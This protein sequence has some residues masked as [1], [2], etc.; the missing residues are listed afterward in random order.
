MHICTCTLSSI[1]V[2]AQQEAWEGH[3]NGHRVPLQPVA[4]GC[5]F[6]C[7][8][9]ESQ[10]TSMTC[11]QSGNCAQLK[12]TWWNHVCNFWLSKIREFWT[13]EDG[14]VRPVAWH[15]V[16]PMWEGM[17]VNLIFSLISLPFPYPPPQTKEAET[18]TKAKPSLHPIQPISWDSNILCL[19]PP[20]PSDTIHSCLE[21][22]MQKGFV[23]R[24][25][26]QLSPH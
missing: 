22:K 1:P 3:L 24:W 12:R 20:I 7:H 23:C 13:K 18:A 25:A 26:V 2:K 4:L 14:G 17:F 10:V 8:S 16:S 6:A 19:F 11:V 15:E 9:L 5:L 21:R